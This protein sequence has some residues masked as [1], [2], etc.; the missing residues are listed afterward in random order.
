MPHLKCEACRARVRSSAGEV[1]TWADLCPL[2]GRPLQPVGELAELVGYRSVAPREPPW[3][4]SV[5]ASG[6]QRLADSVADIA[7]HRWP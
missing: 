7:R 6:Y 5:S 4:D 1:T 3:R 2:C